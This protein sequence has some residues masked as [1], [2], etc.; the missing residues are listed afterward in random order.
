MDEAYAIALLG[1]G[2]Q[3]AASTKL[4]SLG[5]ESSKQ[6]NLW[7]NWSV[8]SLLWGTSNQKESGVDRLQSRSSGLGALEKSQA[9]LALSIASGGVKK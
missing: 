9:E 2:Q 3:A 4:V 5:C 6:F 1:V 8:W 7:Y